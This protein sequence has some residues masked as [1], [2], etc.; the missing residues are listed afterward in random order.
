MSVACSEE[1]FGE[2]PAWA[3]RGFVRV[4]FIPIV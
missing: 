3:E 1:I 4:V 2:P